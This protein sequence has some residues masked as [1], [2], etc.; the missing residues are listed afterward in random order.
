MWAAIPF[1][2]GGQEFGDHDGGSAGKLVERR[3]QGE[4]HAQAADE[5]AWV[6]EGSRVLTG[7]CGQGFF[8]TMHA[9]GHER[10]I[11]GE[12]QVFVAAANQL[13]EGAVWCE[14]LAE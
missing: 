11:V 1:H 9:A 8:G 3:A 4:A 13:E 2:H 5:N 7:E 10:L 12:N 14:L 6:S